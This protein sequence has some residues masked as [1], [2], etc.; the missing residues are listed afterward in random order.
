MPPLTLLVKSNF[1][2]ALYLETRR[3]LTKHDSKRRKLGTQQQAKTEI[4]FSG[5]W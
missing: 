5:R 4:R 3:R 2:V 1:D